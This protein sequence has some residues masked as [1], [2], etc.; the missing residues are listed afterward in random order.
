MRLRRVL[1]SIF[2]A[3][4]FHLFP[5]IILTISIALISFFIFPSTVLIND[6]FQWWEDT[7]AM[8]IHLFVPIAIYSSCSMANTPPW[9][10][11]IPQFFLLLLAKKRLIIPSR[12]TRWPGCKAPSWK[13][14]SLICY[15]CE[16]WVQSDCS[17]RWEQA[18]I[19]LVTVW[20]EKSPC[21]FCSHPSRHGW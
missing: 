2:P 8:H 9:A 13:T 17:H 1:I 12:A 20:K 19:G 4:P 15:F 16:K 3:S 18:K 5:Y 11:V 10:C 7:L 14:Q 6:S 21:W